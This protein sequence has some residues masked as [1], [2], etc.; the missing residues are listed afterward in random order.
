MSI[1]ANELRIGNWVEANMPPMK[2]VAIWHGYV[3]LCFPAAE[4]D[5]WDEEIENVSGIP[6]T[7]EILS[8]AGF[9]TKDV[10][11]VDC[12]WHIPFGEVFDIEQNSD[13]FSYYSLSGR[14]IPVN[15]VHK[16]QN[17]YY[18]LKERHNEQPN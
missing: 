15:S 9:E 10:S 6:L 18:Q 12:R 5:G 17:L 14:F 13:G 1:A 4:A 7:P 2:V 16:L 11:D 3:E 8:K